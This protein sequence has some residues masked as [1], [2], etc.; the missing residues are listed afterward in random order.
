[1]EPDG[2]L[3]TKAELHIYIL[4][5][6]ASSDNEQSE[7]EI[8]LIKSKTDPDTFNRINEEFSKDSEEES[9]EKIAH[10]MHYYEYSNQEI[11]ELK[12]EIREVFF[13]DKNL[14][15]LEQNLDRI[16]DNIIY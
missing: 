4:L 3:W 16:L 11:S 14:S 8:E 15:I 2:R 6:C 9:L 12:K 7:E 13:I 10:K 5:L 1:M